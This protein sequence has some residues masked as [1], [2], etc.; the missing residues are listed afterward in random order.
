MKRIV[1]NPR[2]LLDWCYEV[3][4]QMTP[5]KPHVVTIE[6]KRNTRTLE[7]NAYLW[8]VVYKTLSDQFFAEHGWDKDDIH[9][10]FL[11]EC[12]GWQKLSGVSRPRVKPVHSSKNLPKQDFSDYIA[13]IQRWAAQNGI[14]IP[15]LSAHR[16]PPVVRPPPAPRSTPRYPSG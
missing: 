10:Y 9:D 6:R 11:G 3:S 15:D 16:L 14:V 8:G 12:F 4:R 5:E 1:R 7:Q 2:E 13:F